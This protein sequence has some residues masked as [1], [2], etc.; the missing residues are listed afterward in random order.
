M[1]RFLFGTASVSN[2]NGFLN[3]KID[4][5]GFVHTNLEIKLIKY[6]NRQACE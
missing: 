4:K 2:N 1:E 6:W 3:L 5:I